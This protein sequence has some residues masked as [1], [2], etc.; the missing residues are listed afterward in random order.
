VVFIC[1]TVSNLIPALLPSPT[2]LELGLIGLLHA[3]FLVRLVRTRGAAARQRAVELES[4]R[5]IKSS[6]KT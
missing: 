4:Y 5:A 3:V 6:A 1:A 2:R